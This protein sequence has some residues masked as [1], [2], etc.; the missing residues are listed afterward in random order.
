MKEKQEDTA[1]V[2]EGGGVEWAVRGRD[3]V[4][5][6]AHCGEGGREGGA[7]IP[8]FYARFRCPYRSEGRGIAEQF[9]YL[10]HS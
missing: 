9:N 6:R 8:L 1:E 10:L 2:G 3:G 7:L 4:A 5:V